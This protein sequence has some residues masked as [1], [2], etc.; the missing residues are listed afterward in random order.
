VQG[1]ERVTTA[2]SEHYR[3]AGWIERLG[4]ALRGP[5]GPRSA[6][7]ALRSLYHRLLLLSTFG[8]GLKAS[9]PGGEA[10]RILPQ[11]RYVT[12]N[13]DEYSAFKRVLRPGHLAFDIGANVG[14]YTVLFGQLVSPGGRV[15]AFEPSPRA[16]EGLT[17]HI[18]LNHLDHVAVSIHSAVA[19]REG[20]AEFI[21][22]GST[23]MDRL[24][25]LEACRVQGAGSRVQGAAPA[26]AAECAGTRQREWGSGP[27]SSEQ[28]AG[29]R[30]PDSGSAE[31]APAPRTQDPGPRIRA[32][33]LRPQDPAPRTQDPGPR[34]R[35]PGPRTQ[36]SSV[37]R[38]DVVTLDGFCAREGLRPDFVK[39]DVEG[40]E[41]AVLRGARRTIQ[42][43]RD[44]LS[45]FVEMHPTVW[46]S[47]GV[48]QA[49]LE[50]ELERQSLRVE[51]L[52]KGQDPWTVE[53]VC[54]KL[55]PH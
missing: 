29:C 20:V 4:D 45:L 36:R 46:P 10:I 19:D 7:S 26:A 24:G 44:R 43:A 47:L 30:V 27:T 13:P 9:L 14:C 6:P 55:I 41:L 51:P 53:G 40:A 3:R 22:V 38:V 18:A 48:A 15:F 11:Y 52:V 25:S 49:D 37:T 50:A 54:V 28:S 8:R 33:G 31:P 34:T 2:G 42:A 32:P 5:L 21:L 1:G 17:R 12:W 16:V 23:G 39:I 35:D